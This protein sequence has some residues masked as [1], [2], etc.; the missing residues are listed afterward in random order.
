MNTVNH[1]DSF[2]VESSTEFKSIVQSR[3]NGLTDALFESTYSTS[4]FLVLRSY[5]IE[6]LINNIIAIIYYVFHTSIV[7]KYY[8]LASVMNYHYIY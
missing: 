7:L 5:V 3:T 1:F 6:Q 8:A 2:T 4:S